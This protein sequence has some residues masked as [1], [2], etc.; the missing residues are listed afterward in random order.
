MASDVAA[1]GSRRFTSQQ[2]AAA[3]REIVT[4]TELR[5][6]ARSM[7]A[8]AK[9]AFVDPN[10]E[11]EFPV[12]LSNQRAAAEWVITHTK[13]RPGTA[14][15]SVDP[16]ELPTVRDAPSALLAYGEILAAVSSGKICADSAKL[17]ASLVGDAAKIA[18][19]HKAVDSLASGGWPEF[20]FSDDRPL[21]EQLPEAMAFFERAM[22]ARFAAVPA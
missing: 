9:G 15:P 1:P 6:V 18:L 14:S 22:R 4:P 7:L 20:L 11:D 3:M 17:Y 19:A 5:A 12:E 8:V 21:D 10:N 13:G 2:Y 16:L